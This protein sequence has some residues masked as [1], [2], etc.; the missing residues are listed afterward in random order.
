M[1]STL[2]HLLFGSSVYFFINLRKKLSFTNYL[3]CLLFSLVADFDYI[4]YLFF[5]VGS[6]ALYHRVFFH[7]IFTFMVFFVFV[8]FLNLKFNGRYFSNVDF[9]VFYGLHLLLDLF[10]NG[11]PL[12]F[13][14]VARFFLLIQVGRYIGFP[15]KLIYEGNIYFSIFV[16]FL[17]AFSLS[18]F[19]FYR[20]WMKK[21]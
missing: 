19:I 6:S 10:D 14:F 1:V 12:L 3:F 7:N 21:G 9:I 11:V 17:Y 13:P 5:P 8:F 18:F 15:L 20:K 4:A 2:S 16:I